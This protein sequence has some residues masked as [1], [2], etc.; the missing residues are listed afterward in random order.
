MAYTMQE[1]VDIA[2]SVLNDPGGITWPDTERLVYA[3]TAADLIYGNYPLAFA[4]S[5]ATA[6]YGKGL[7]LITTWPGPDKWARYI[8]DYIEARCRAKDAAVGANAALAQAALAS[9]K[10]QFPK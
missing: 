1:I 8:V 7:A 3:Q 5:F 9:F 2:D 4:A 6:G 10:A